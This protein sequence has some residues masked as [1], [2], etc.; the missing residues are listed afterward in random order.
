MFRKLIGAFAGLAM[1]GMAGTAN[2][3][4]LNVSDGQLLGATGVDVGGTLYDVT[5]VDGTCIALFDGCNEIADFDFTDQATALLACQALLDQVLTDTVA[6][7]F[8]TDPELTFGCTFSSLCG[9]LIPFVLVAP[10]VSAANVENASSTGVDTVTLSGLPT[11]AGTTSIGNLNYVQFQPSPIPEPSTFAL[12]AT[13]LALL[14]FLGWR[15]RGA[16]Q[17]KA[18]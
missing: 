4:V 10:G 6:G 5:F 17:V 3:V 2:A 16:V 15:R 13:G 14:A 12:F 11:G 18:A 8:D 9:T 1:M 7:L